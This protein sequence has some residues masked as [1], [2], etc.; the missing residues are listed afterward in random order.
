MVMQ[1]IEIRVAMMV[2][3]GLPLSAVAKATG[4][5]APCLVQLLASVQVGGMVLEM[6]AKRAVA[7]WSANRALANHIDRDD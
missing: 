5:C 6:E 1:D 7:G 2:A 4:L 3:A